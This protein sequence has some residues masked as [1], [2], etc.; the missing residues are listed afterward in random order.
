MGINDAAFAAFRGFSIYCIDAISGDR[1]TVYQAKF[2]T[3]CSIE[4][5]IADLKSEMSKMKGYREKLNYWKPVKKWILFTNVEENPNDGEKWNTAVEK[6]DY[7]GLEIEIWGWPKIRELLEKYP[8]VKQDFLENESR[9]FLLKNEFQTKSLEE[10]LP[11]SFDVEC[12]GCEKELQL[13][14]NFW[15]QIGKF[16]AFLVL[17]ERE[18]LGS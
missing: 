4:N 15:N 5:C 12:V 10:Y 7:C 3:Q 1:Q 13:F 18:N 11:E 16:G 9:C 2:H 8:E 17:E 6:C 14:K